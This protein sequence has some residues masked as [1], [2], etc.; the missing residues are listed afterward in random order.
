MH[1]NNFAILLFIHSFFWHVEFYDRVFAHFWLNVQ[2][3]TL[4]TQ[5][6]LL[7]ILLYKSENFHGHKSGLNEHPEASY[8]LSPNGHSV[9]CRIKYILHWCTFRCSG[10]LREDGDWFTSVVVIVFSLSLLRS[11]RGR[12]WRR[13]WNRVSVE[14]RGIRMA[15]W[16]IQEWGDRE[17]KLYS[18]K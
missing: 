4:T 3:L 10:L 12:P 18:W 13:C 1:N 16:D 5:W 6:T 17:R 7:F 15:K 8:H 11:S 2:V 14:H 9:F